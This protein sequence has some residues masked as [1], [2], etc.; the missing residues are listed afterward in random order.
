M[1]CHLQPVY[2]ALYPG[3][4]LENT[5]RALREVLILPLYP[6]MTDAEQD[7]VLTELGDALKSLPR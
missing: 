1:A 4:R 2:Q 3:L 5:E 7:H 6:Q